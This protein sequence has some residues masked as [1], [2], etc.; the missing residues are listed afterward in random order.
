MNG[1]WTI[2]AGRPDASGR[3]EPWMTD[4]DGVVS[5]WHA[6]QPTGRT[7]GSTGEPTFHRFEPEAV[8]ASA[9]ATARHFGLEG[10]VSTW[11]ALPASGTGGR[12]AVWRALARGWDLTVSQPS[13][14]PAVP[15]RHGGGRFDF[16]VATP[17]QARHL[18]ASNQLLRFHQLLLGG[19][20]VDPELEAVLVEA[21]GRAG[22]RIHHGFGMTETLT[23]VAV[24]PL[25]SDCFRPLTGVDLAIGPQGALIVHAP[26]RGVFQLMTRDA[27]SW[28]DASRSRDFRWLG[29]LDDVLNSGGLKVHPHRLEQDIRA[30]LEPALGG[31]RW[32]VAGRPDAALGQSITLVIEGHRDA[33]IEEKA[34]AFCRGLGTIRPR[35]IEFMTVFEETATGKV[36]RK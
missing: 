26:E 34:L 18:A 14:H 35:A 20:P 36:R 4:F 31:R 3:T 32:Y 25:G 1:T 2:V 8:R 33:L 19:A 17:M 29:R 28:A 22:C 6:G 5:E 12:M 10:R 27:A 16:A 15:V 23:H 21:G 7:S 11:S 13:A 30:G 9:A 24:R